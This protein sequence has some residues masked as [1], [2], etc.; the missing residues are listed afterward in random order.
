MYR[1]PSGESASRCS[2]PIALGLSLLIGA[3]AAPPL[4]F[5]QQFPVK[6]IRLITAAAPGSIPD[7]VAR[8]LAERLTDE[9]HQ[10][11]I[12]ENRPGAGGIVAINLVVTARPDGHTIG[13]VSMAQM[14]FNAYL[15][16][17]LPYDPV[18]DLTPVVNLLSGP[19][20]VAVHPSFPANSL[21]ELIVLARTQPGRLHY[22]VPQLGAPPH[23]FALMLC[24]AMQ[25]DL[26]AVPFRGAPEALGSVVAGVVPIVFDAPLI[27]A[28][29]VKA[30]T[31]KAI[32]VTGRERVRLLP[33]TPTLAE[34]G[35]P[36]LDLEAWL[37][38]VA[39]ANVP[40]T[41]IAKINDATSRALRTPALKQHFERLGWRILEGSPEEFASTILD[42]HATWGPI[43]RKSGLKLQ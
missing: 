16:E 5:A 36:K 24:Q 29:H 1:R 23:I 30:G 2:F 27:V 25:I 11:V 21:R 17:N 38:L 7:T 12:V 13:L 26:V 20:A 32:A 6:P 15:F 10:P 35:F 31:L 4:A 18:R 22:A 33:E 14:V 43:I 41:I 28:Q 9:L 42:D 3:M 40:P 37:G 34:S 8:P 19:L 39:P